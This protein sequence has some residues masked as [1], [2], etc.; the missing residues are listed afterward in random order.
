MNLTDI[1]LIVVVVIQ[2]YNVI[3]S[4]RLQRIIKREMDNQ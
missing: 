2:I 3:L 1:I 4:I